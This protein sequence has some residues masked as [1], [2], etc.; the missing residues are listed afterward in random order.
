MTTR[1]PVRLAAFAFTLFTLGPAA[2]SQEPAGR[3]IVEGQNGQSALL[4][5][6]DATRNAFLQVTRDDQTNVTLLSYAFREPDPQNPALKRQIS[7]EGEIPAE[8]FT[9]TGQSARL[10]LTTPEAFPV[11]RC[12]IDEE[13][14]D[15]GCEPGDAS[16]FDLTWLADGYGSLKSSST[17]VETL[18]SGMLRARGSYEELTALAGGVWNDAPLSGVTGVLT[19]AVSR[20]VWREAG[21]PAARLLRA[22]VAPV[23]LAGASGFGQNICQ[24]GRQAWSFL[25]DGGL[26]GF[27][28]A[29]RDELAQITHLRFGYA[30]PD[31]ADPSRTLFYFADGEVPNDS[32][33]ITAKSARLSLTTPASLPIRC[34][35]I[36]AVIGEPDAITC[37]T[38]DTP[39]TLDLSWAA[40]GVQ[41]THRT[42]STVATS[43]TVTTASH[44]QFNEASALIT[45]TWR[46]LVDHAATDLSGRLLNYRDATITR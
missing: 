41:T 18:E 24:N 5:L 27:V 7:G 19:T 11:T 38:S 26:N 28:S 14:G 44:G 33:Q 34:C 6:A 42:E 39:V 4:I 32:L 13:T 30:F 22:V 16:T 45:G 25:A 36:T 35:V 10:S 8:A 12:L 43:G 15:V 9:T 40:D 3:A 46:D 37:T 21:S 20:S 29:I 1:T 2:A 17:T 23:E 31:D